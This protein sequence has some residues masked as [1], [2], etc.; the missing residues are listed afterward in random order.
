MIHIRPHSLLHKTQLCSLAFQSFILVSPFQV[1][2]ILCCLLSR[3]DGFLPHSH[4][5]LCWKDGQYF[6]GQLFL[7]LLSA[8]KCSYFSFLSCFLLLNPSLYMAPTKTGPSHSFSYMLPM[9]L[10]CSLFDPLN[11]VGSL[12]GQI[13]CLM[14]GCGCKE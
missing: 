12:R 8:L 10:F 4:L 1:C 7:K 5:C 3:E 11:W 2:Y 14:G 9:L 13:L 6:E